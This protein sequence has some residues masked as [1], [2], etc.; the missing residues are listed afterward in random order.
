M[1]TGV[2][3]NVEVRRRVR[4]G[5][6]DIGVTNLVPSR[7]LREGYKPICGLK[8]RRRTLPKGVRLWKGGDRNTERGDEVLKKTVF[9]EPV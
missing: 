2:R 6:G 3:C 4:D 1:S 8:S 7:G 9:L 5:G